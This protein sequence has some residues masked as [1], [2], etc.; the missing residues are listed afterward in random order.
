[1][2][3]GDEELTQNIQDW[4]RYVI[5]NSSTWDAATYNTSYAALAEQQNPFNIRTYPLSLPAFKAR[6]GKLL[7]YH[8]GQ[9]NQITSFNTERF[10]DRMASADADLQDWYRFFR[11]S[12]M[13]HCSQGPG[14][15]VLGQGGG[16][17]A[18][19]IPFEAS[20]N[21]L[22]ALVDWVEKGRKPESLT[23][24]KFVDDTVGNGVDFERVHCL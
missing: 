17:A 8:G 9:D 16:A 13:F 20:K 3:R 21:V 19:G 15:W 24:T 12:G 6:G 7:S 22:A 11:I 1:M 23:G 2:T 10:W 5:L 14:A 18:E 4:F